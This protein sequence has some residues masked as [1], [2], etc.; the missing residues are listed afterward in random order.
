MAYA[1]ITVEKESEAS[2]LETLTGIGLNM[3]QGVMYG[4]DATR[5]GCPITNFE[6]FAWIRMCPGVL[7]VQEI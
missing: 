3:S 1:V 2:V 4:A 6:Q 7:D 5:I